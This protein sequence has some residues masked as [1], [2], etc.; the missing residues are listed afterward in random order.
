[1]TPKKLAFVV[2]LSALTALPLTASSAESNTYP[3]IGCRWN[4]PAGNDTCFDPQSDNNSIKNNC[5]SDKALLCPLHFHDYLD[6]NKDVVDT[7]SIWFDST[8]G[9]SCWLSKA[10]NGTVTHYSPNSTNASNF[11]WSIDLNINGS[12][13]EVY[14]FSIGCWVDNYNKVYKYKASVK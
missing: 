4:D 9:S 13:G 10:Y 5:S 12:S 1:M 3:G 7:A 6:I 11:G 8:T 14:D 2:S